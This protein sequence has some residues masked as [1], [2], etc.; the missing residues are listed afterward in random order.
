MTTA[1]MH[2]NFY[3]GNPLDRLA[4]RRDDEGYLLELLHDPASRFLP[5]WRDQ[6]LI[7]VEASD[8]LR[9]GMPSREALGHPVETLAELPWVLLGLQEGHAVFAV[10][11]GGLEEPGALVPP[12]FGRFEPL[13]PL[14]PSLPG[15]E[16]AILAQARGL[17]HWR[18]NHLFC[19]HCGTAT[20]PEQGGY[21]LG[22]PNCG[23][24]HFPRTDPVVIMLVHHEGRALLARGTRFPG[25]RLF[26][27]L[28]GFIEPGESAEEAVAREVFEETGVRLRGHRLS[29]QPA[30]AVSEL[31]DARVPGRGR[32]PHAY[33]RYQRDRRGALADARR[34]TASGT[35]RHRAARRDRHRPQPGRRMAGLDPG[36]LVAPVPG[37]A[38]WRRGRFVMRVVALR[39]DVLRVRIGR[40]RALPEDASWA[41]LPEARLRHVA[42]TH[43]PGG[44]SHR[45]RA[46]SDRR[47]RRHAG[48]S[49]PRRTH[50]PRDAADAPFSESE[51]SS[52]GNGHGFTITKT[53]PAETHIFGLG[54]KAGQLDRRGRSFVMWNT[55]AY[56]Y[57]ESSEPLYKDIPFF[58]GFERGRA[59]GLFLD[60]TFRS[61]FEFG[62]R[63]PDR[64]SFGADGGAIDY[65]IMAGPTP[66]DV[67]RAYAWLTGPPPLPPLWS[68]GY[69][70]CR[71]TYMS[72]AEAMM[73]AH[74]MRAERMPCDVIWFDIDV[75]EGHRAFSINKQAYPDFPGMVEE[76]G[77][78]GYRAIVI[79]DLHVARLQGAGYV[80]WDSGS[81]GNHFVHDAKGG[82][83]IG[84]V[85]PGDCAFPD[86]TRKATRDWWGT[87]LRSEVLVD[88][89]AGIWND[90]NE[91]SVFGTPTRTMPLDNVHRIEEPGFTTRTASHREIHNVFGMQNARATYRWHAGR[92]AGPAPVRDVTRDLRRRP[93]HLRRVDR[94]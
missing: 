90:M 64:L 48:G 43:E 75:L 81:A 2:A 23:M 12:T 80:P 46:R 94:G 34:G 85:W 30:L 45:N 22:C 33:P 42:V 25:R 32:G 35:S 68:F 69:Q 72:Q 65:Y 15:P 74:R 92:A 40:S 11:L 9:V 60:N 14:A 49:R 77:R 84:K 53:L 5:V 57:Q 21:R 54:E 93:A 29:F 8:A 51:P 52:G 27:A 55:D 62:V 1:A 58:V 3:T 6:H 37:G 39:D 7:G 59:Y 31:A 88:H 16:A 41:V 13:R 4:L 19:G 86:F 73:V 61:R 44:F 47:L 91:P 66:A 17:L 36:P 70:Q 18:R 71:F 89:V 26:S 82:V 10:D 83:Y 50:D 67:Q 56:R 79:T 38:E 76:L 63:H 24:Q 78:L 87:L 28:A 20:I